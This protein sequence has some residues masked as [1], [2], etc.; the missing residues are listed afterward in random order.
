[1]GG[2]VCEAVRRAVDLSLVAEV[3]AWRDIVA[4]EASAAQVAVDFTHPDTVM[5]NV[6][7]CIAHGVHAVVGTTGFTDLRLQ[8]LRSWLEDAPSVGIAVV[9]NFGIGAVLMMQFAE[10]AARYFESAEIIELHHPRKVDAPSGTA[11]HVAERIVRGRNGAGLD[12]MPDS[13]ATAIEGA[14]GAAVGG[15][16][17][18]SLRL[19]GLVAHHRLLFGGQGEVLEIRHDSF[20]RMSFMPGVL[21]AVRAIAARPGLTLGLESFLE[22]ADDLKG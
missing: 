15:V 7:W 22:Q 9:P 3:A 18:H 6:E 8:Q 11:C 4:M 20:D 10:T 12:G 21:L 16:P 19:S 17:V 13:T 2:A 5:H 14:R 1:M